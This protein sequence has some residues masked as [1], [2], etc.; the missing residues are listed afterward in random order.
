[1]YKR[2]SVNEG[3]DHSTNDHVPNGTNDHV[4]NEFSEGL[5][6]EKTELDLITRIGVSGT[7]EVFIWWLYCDVGIF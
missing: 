5:K 3:E 2:S 4:P 6:A 7:Q 1:M